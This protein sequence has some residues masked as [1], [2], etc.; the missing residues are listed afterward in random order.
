MILYK[1]APDYYYETITINK[2]RIIRMNPTFF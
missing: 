1:N 2:K